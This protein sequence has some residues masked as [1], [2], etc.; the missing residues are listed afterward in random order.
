MMLAEIDTIGQYFSVFKDFTLKAPIELSYAAEE[1]K[2][3]TTFK[4]L[5]KSELTFFWTFL[6]FIIT[7]NEI[8]S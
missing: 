2:P 4:T 3:N 8:H 5:Y 1:W 7:G 6:M